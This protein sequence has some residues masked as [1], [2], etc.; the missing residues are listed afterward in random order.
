MGYE[1]SSGKGLFDRGGESSGSGLYH[2]KDGERGKGYGVAYFS[3]AKGTDISAESYGYTKL[4]L[5]HAGNIDAF[6]PKGVLGNVQKGQ[7]FITPRDLPI[8]AKANTDAVYTEIALKEDTQMNQILKA[9]QVMTL[10][11]LLPYQEGKIVNMDLVNDPHLKF[12]IMSL[13]REPVYQSMLLREKR[14][15]SP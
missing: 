6:D 11:D 9:G 3:L 14:L 12:V 1:R 13:V 8:G 15:S 7:I 10:K 5:I 4:W 2:I